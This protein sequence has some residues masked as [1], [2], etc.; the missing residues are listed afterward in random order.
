LHIA[1]SVVGESVVGDALAAF[2]L[3]D[4]VV[5]V[6]EVFIHVLEDVG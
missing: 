6:D 4:D 5:L 1:A 2:F 3:D